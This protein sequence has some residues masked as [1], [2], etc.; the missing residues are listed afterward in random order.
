M[1]FLSL[2]R[3]YRPE[4]F[5]DLIG[6]DQVKQTLKNALKN[7]R[8]AHAYLFAGPRGT[9]K[10]SA[11]K[12]FAKSLNCANPTPDFEPCGECNSCQRI[13]KGNSLDVIEI[14]A[15]SNRGIDEIRE[16]REKV[17]FYPGEGKHK[18]YI[19][20]EVHMLTK[21]AFNAL[22]KTLEEPPESVVFILATTEPHAVITTIMSRCQRFDFTLLTLTNL[23]KRLKYI[24]DAEGYEIDKEALD[25]L[26]RSARGGMRDAISLLDQAI[27]FSD[28]Q[29]SLEEVSRMLGRIDKSDL[30][31]FLLHLSNKK[32]QPALELLNKQL[33]S[34]LGIER[35][36]DE[37]IEYCRELLLIKE[38]G[39]DSGILEYS[40][41]YLEEIASA[42][43]NLSTKKITNIIDEFASLK[44]KL[45]SSARP[46][47]QLEISVIKLSSRGSS[48]SSLEARLS[49][50][51]FKLDNFLTNQDS[52]EFKSGLELEKSAAEKSEQKKIESGKDQSEP[53]PEETAADEP[54]AETHTPAVEADKSS[55]SDQSGPKNRQAKKQIESV[56]KEKNVS[57]KDTSRNAGSNAE[58]SKQQNQNTAAAGA[59]I[60]LSQVKESW[61]RV[62]KEIRQLDISVQALLR[63]GS[64]AAVEGKTI[65]IAFPEDKKFHYKGAASNEALIARVLRNV[66]NEAVEP[67]FQLGAKKK[68]TEQSADRDSDIQ[69]VQKNVAQT[70][71]VDLVEDSSPAAGQSEQKTNLS[72]SSEPDEADEFS[73]SDQQKSEK[74]ESEAEEPASQGREQKPE[75]AGDLDIEALAR[76]FSG[77]IIEVDQ[78]ILENRGGN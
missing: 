24:A 75:Q 6:Q 19:I 77:E 67:E 61:A 4:N 12:V 44:D 25:I 52:S 28:G 9:G 37:L 60:S 50:L 33:E 29:L 73:K 55:K 56:K 1:S 20:D 27:S 23:K 40:R 45:R 48:S 26:A 68:I 22:L 11:A 10:T 14:D 31:E 66:L 51:E 18:V 34:G 69:T 59:D 62:L 38:C 70:E 74:N 2:Y 5:N 30:K 32:S 58:R 57:E 7:D 36:S 39:I 64:P 8:V 16:L 17:K 49:E 53:T 42:A 78:S 15:A 13:E 65:V 72:H 21:G 43:A 35:F 46:R 71:A 3:K 54:A 47:L 41:S 63:E 76:I